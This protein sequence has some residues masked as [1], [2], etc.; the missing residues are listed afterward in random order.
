[1]GD[2]FSY[3]CF[4]GILFW[5]KTIVIRRMLCHVIS[6]THTHVHTYPHMIQLHYYYKVC[7][8]LLGELTTHNTLSL[9]LKR[10][11]DDQDP[12]AFDEVVLPERTHHCLLQSIA[13]I[14]RGSSHRLD[15]VYC[16][17]RFIIYTMNPC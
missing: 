12:S 11:G 15:T 7:L 5:D 2:K 17:I 4:I 9:L 14:V 1:M 3:P 13:G 8:H 16:K 10:D 6:V